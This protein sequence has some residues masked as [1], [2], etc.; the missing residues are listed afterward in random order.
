MSLGFLAFMP[1]LSYG[2]V[3]LL[4]NRGCP[5]AASLKAANED[6]LR[7][8]SEITVRYCQI[9]R[10]LEA[11]APRASCAVIACCGMGGH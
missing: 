3:R 9:A 10:Y 8:S 11:S 5:L 1:D 2:F 6:P 7:E 4:K